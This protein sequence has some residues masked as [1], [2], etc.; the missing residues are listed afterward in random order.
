MLKHTRSS[1]YPA[2]YLDSELSFDASLEV[3]RGED[4]ALVMGDGRVTRGESSGIISGEAGGGEGIPLQ[5]KQ[6]GRRQHSPRYDR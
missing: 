3:R 2:I 1:H 5:M 4:L 6:A